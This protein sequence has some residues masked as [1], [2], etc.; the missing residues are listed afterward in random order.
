MRSAVIVGVIVMLTGVGFS[1][2]LS[3]RPHPKCPQGRPL[4]KR[5]ASCGSTTALGGG[6][7]STVH[8]RSP[9]LPLR[10]G[11]GAWRD[12]GTL[13]D[14]RNTSRADALWEEG[15]LYVVSRDRSQPAQRQRPAFYASYDPST[16]RYSLDEGFPVTITEGGMEAI[17]VARDT[18]ASSGP[19]MPRIRKTTSCAAST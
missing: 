4:R 15:H 1:Q 14:G 6:Y 17:T 3:F 12:T 7:F 18:T 2:Q 19:L 11:K 10:S 5:K 16:N 9:H 8:P 13:V